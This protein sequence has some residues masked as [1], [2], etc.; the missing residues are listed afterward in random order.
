MALL[1]LEHRDDALSTGDVL[2]EGDGFLLVATD[3]QEVIDVLVI[4]QRRHHDQQQTCQ[5]RQQSEAEPATL[6]QEVIDMEEEGKH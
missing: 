1:H 2:I 3:R 5:Q 4:F 6:V